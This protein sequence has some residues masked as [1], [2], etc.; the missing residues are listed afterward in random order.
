MA[1]SGL[2]PVTLSHPSSVWSE[3]AAL[4]AQLVGFQSKIEAYA[5]VEKKLE[6]ITDEPTWQAMVSGPSLSWEVGEEELCWRRR[7]GERGAQGRGSGSKYSNLASLKRSANSPFCS[8]ARR[9]EL[10]C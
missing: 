1:T 8:V 2:R 5:K 7:C 10:A 3:V 4:K 9:L 6:T